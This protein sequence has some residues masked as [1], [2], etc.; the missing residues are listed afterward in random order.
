MSYRRLS[1]PCG[2]LATQERAGV[3]AVEIVQVSHLHGGEDSCKLGLQTPRLS[4]SR[5]LTAGD[6]C[7]SWHQ[8]EM[9]ALSPSQ[10]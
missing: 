1:G 5:T 4:R 9:E 2:H 10:H 8:G 7:H 6:K 3:T